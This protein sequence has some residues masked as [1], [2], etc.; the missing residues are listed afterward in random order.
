MSYPQ[1]IL[2]NQFGE[3]SNSTILGGSSQIGCSFVVDSTNG[4][5]LGIRSL[6]TLGYP[7]VSAVYMHTSSTPAS[8][9]PNPAVGLILVQFGVAFS[10]YVG[11]FSGFVSPV[12]GTPI[13]VTAGLTVGQAYIITT[14]GTTTAAQW[15]TLGLPTNIVPAVGASFIAITAS[16]GVG[17]GAVEVPLATGSGINHIE[18]VGDP[19]QNV[20]TTSG[21]GSMIL[22]TLAATSSSVTTLVATAPA[23]NSVIG[24]SFSMLAAP[25]PL[26]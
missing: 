16:A 24:L 25:A 12:S 3:Q 13:L 19:N 20:Q 21:G 11:G 15:Q 4:N 26:I 14:V 2:K 6:K 17:T 23:N 9:N 7:A 1:I 10:G 5:G 22:T 18:V 8:G